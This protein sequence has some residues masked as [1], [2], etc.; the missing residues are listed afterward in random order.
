MVLQQ[1]DDRHIKS[2]RL[3]PSSGGN[4]NIAGSGAVGGNS[5]SGTGKM[6]HRSKA[7]PQNNPSYEKHDG[8]THHV[9]AGLASSE[10]SRGI[11]FF[12]CI[13]FSFFGKLLFLRRKT[14]ENI[15]TD[16]HAHTLF[17]TQCI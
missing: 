8:T 17:R 9:R 2:I 16:T 10:R 7:H 6:S 13:L 15:H 12:G 11:Y 3:H 4:G 14:K 5:G 1:V